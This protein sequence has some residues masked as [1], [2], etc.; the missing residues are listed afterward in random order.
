MV[1]PGVCAERT[2]AVS[3]PFLMVNNSISA[4]SPAT[5]EHMKSFMATLQDMPVFIRVSPAVFAQLR[6]GLP[7]ASSVLGDHLGGLPM[8]VDMLLDGHKA[9]VQYRSG[10]IELLDLKPKEK[11]MHPDR[12]VFVDAL[13]ANEDDHTTRMIYADWL[14]E[15]DEPEE[16]DR[17]RKLPAAKEWLRQWVQKING[18][19]P[20]RLAEWEAGLQEWMQGRYDGKPVTTDMGPLTEDGWSEWTGDRPQADWYQRHSYEDA[21][22]AGHS[23]LSGEGYCFGTDAGCDYFYPWK[24]GEV[25]GSAEFFRNWSIV[26]GVPVPESVVKEP[27]FRCAC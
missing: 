9:L 26:T 8:Q 15:H 18:D 21:I 27:P 4:S 25:S 2:A 7:Q 17:M 12:Q 19:Y 1:A 23:A 16:A 10:R 20:R 14:D 5:L 6:D 11:P 3:N 24:K 22:A 13:A